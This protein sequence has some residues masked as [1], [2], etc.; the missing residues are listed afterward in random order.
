M[1]KNKRKKGKKAE[2]VF[3]EHLKK[4]GFTVWR[5]TNCRFGK[6]DLFGLF[7]IVALDTKG[8][9]W[10]I[11]VKTGS[12]SNFYTSKKKIAE[13]YSN[14]REPDFFVAVVFVDTRKKYVRID[15]EFKIKEWKKEEYNY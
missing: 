5:P 13:F 14:F 12:M 10:L 6:N 7:D 1:L 2:K 11:Q 3:V 15:Y 9:I 8:Y 4:K